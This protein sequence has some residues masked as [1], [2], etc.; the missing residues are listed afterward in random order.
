MA[1][2]LVFASIVQGFSTPP[3][4]LML[5]I[6]TNRRSVMGEHVNG[7]WLNV[8]GW[9]ATASVFAAAGGLV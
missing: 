4:L 9:T 1:R 2:A 6:L 5:M 8:L 7:R 3:L